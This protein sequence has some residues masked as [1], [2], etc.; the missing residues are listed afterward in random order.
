MKKYIKYGVFAITCMVGLWGYSQNR[1]LD[2]YSRRITAL[3]PLTNFHAWAEFEKEVLS[4]CFQCCERC[5][6]AS[7]HDNQSV[8]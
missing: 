5:D 3:L 2:N 6:C 1:N 8:G 7:G 4:L